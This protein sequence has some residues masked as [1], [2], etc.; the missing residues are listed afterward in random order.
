MYEKTVCAGNVPEGL[1]LEVGEDGAQL[2]VGGGE[3]RAAFAQQLGGTAVRASMS[4]ASDCM[5]RNMASSSATAWL[6]DSSATGVNLGWFVS[7]CWCYA[8]VSVSVDVNEPCATVVVNSAPAG[9]AAG[10][11][12]AR[13]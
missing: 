6:Y 5:L 11:V 13:P 3:T 12:T 1:F 2:L 8:F 9:R 4:Q 7:M 10:S